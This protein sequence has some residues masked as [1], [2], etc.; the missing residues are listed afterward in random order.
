[1]KINKNIFYTLFILILACCSLSIAL[2]SQHYFGAD[3]CSWCIAQR[4][5]IIL[6]ILSS[7]SIGFVNEK[8]A[9]IINICLSMLGI[10][11]AIYQTYIVT[12]GSDC[13]VSLA[14]KIIGYTKLNNLLPSIFESYALC[15]DSIGTF[16]SVSFVTWGFVLF[17]IVFIV[18]IYHLIS[19]SNSLSY[20][21]KKADE[22]ALS[23]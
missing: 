3:P 12:V 18:S 22:K 9:T 19:D 13:S 16:L 8:L 4:A 17:I 23:E 21:L 10:T 14:E 2:V 15:T 7:A 5:V 6:I 1:M 11:I 20:F